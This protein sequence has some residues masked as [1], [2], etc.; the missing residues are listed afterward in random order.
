MDTALCTH[1]SGAAADQKVRASRFARG[2]RLGWPHTSRKRPTRKAFTRRSSG[3]VLQV[4]P[5][6]T[7]PRSM[8]GIGAAPLAVGDVLLLSGC[9][10]H[11]S[12]AGLIP[13]GIAGSARRSLMSKPATRRSSNGGSWADVVQIRRQTA[14]EYR[15]VPT[16]GLAPITVLR[17][18]HG[19]L[20]LHLH[21]GSAEPSRTISAWRFGPLVTV[22]EHAH[23]VVAFNGVFKMA[24][25]QGGW[26]SD[27]RVVVP[28]Q[29]GGPSVVIY[30]DGTADI[31]PGAGQTPMKLQS[32]AAV[33]GQGRRLTRSVLSI[34]QNVVVLVR[35]GLAVTTRGLSS[36]AVRARWGTTFGGAQY[37]AR[38]GLGI[39]ASG[40]VV[41][42]ASNNRTS[43]D[44]LAVALK[45]AGAVRAIQLDINAPLVRSFLFPNAT[46][47]TAQ[48][49]PMARD[50]P[51]SGSRTDASTTTEHP[52]QQSSAALQLHDPLQP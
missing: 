10:H 12:A 3:L 48:E 14:V 25:V 44:T 30:A 1:H 5:R 52:H 17:V 21:A 7:G 27:G 18:Q 31:L 20:H 37:V 15:Q 45:N 43:V 46:G 24:D 28:L 39:T 11:S 49:P 2:R 38:S 50:H 42:A 33:R 26:M 41:W 40:M 13:A 51:S 6:K 36:A 47:V 23:L 16:P 29:P 9:G 22:P 19:L 4:N 34:R 32:A 35:D 8:R